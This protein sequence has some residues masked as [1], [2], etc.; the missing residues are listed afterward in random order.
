MRYATIT[1]ILGPPHGLLA[2]DSPSIGGFDT[3]RDPLGAT[4]TDTI[5]VYETDTHNF[6]DPVPR[7][8][9]GKLTAARKL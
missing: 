1:S 7:P 5:N 6:V 3:F 2:Q 9:R 8:I 4:F